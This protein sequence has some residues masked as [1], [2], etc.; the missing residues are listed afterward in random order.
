MLSYPESTVTE[1]CCRTKDWSDSTS[2]MMFRR[3]SKSSISSAI[4]WVGRVGPA[5]FALHTVEPKAYSAATD[6]VFTVAGGHQ[7]AMGQAV[8]LYN[9]AG[10]MPWGGMAQDVLAG[11]AYYARVIDATTLTLHT[12][13]LKA[14]TINP[15][16]EVCSVSVVASMTRA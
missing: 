8:R 6:N 5:K 13:A 16:D 3:L 2:S 12:K 1:R 11:S 15:A 10:N 4:D 7:L 9:D 14:F